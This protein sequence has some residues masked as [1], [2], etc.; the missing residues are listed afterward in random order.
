M[1]AL[2][3]RVLPHLLL[4]APP[5]RGWR[6]AG[7]PSEQCARGSGCHVVWWGG[8]VLTCCT[9]GPDSIAFWPAR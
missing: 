3:T 4:A 7:C 5:N 9:H 1:T 6:G 8:E 2:R